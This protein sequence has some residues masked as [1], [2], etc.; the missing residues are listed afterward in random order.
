MCCGSVLLGDAPSWAGEHSPVVT[1][2]WCCQAWLR[3]LERL[4]QENSHSSTAVRLCF[5]LAALVWNM[6]ETCHSNKACLTS[7]HIKV[8][9]WSFCF[10]SVLEAALALLNLE[11]QHPIQWLPVLNSW[12]CPSHYTSPHPIALFPPQP[13]GTDLMVHR[14]Q[15]PR[16]TCS[17][18]IRINLPSSPHSPSLESS[19]LPH[20]NPCS[21]PPVLASVVGH[22]NLH[23]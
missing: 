5:S 21:L 22:W 12:K 9:Q 13:G 3:W 10:N 11:S 1:A 15:L 23:K 2:A 20:T 6:T 4:T 19:L 17:S 8:V 16:E 18:I 7:S 14:P